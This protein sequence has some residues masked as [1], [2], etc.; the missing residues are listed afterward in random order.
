[1]FYI[2]FNN[3]KNCLYVTNGTQQNQIPIYSTPLLEEVIKAVPVMEKSFKLKE[4][5]TDLSNI[6]P[7]INVASSKAEIEFDLEIL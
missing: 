4:N 7:L 5:S 1:M 2:Y 6:S 3:A